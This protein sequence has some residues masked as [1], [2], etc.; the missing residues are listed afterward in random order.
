[1]I[2]RYNYTGRKRI[3]RSDV[4]VFVEDSPLRFEIAAFLSEYKL[5][6]EAKVFV[7]AY[8]QTNWMRFDCGKVGE[9]HSGLTWPLTEFDTREGILF[10][11]RVSESESLQGRLLAEA[12][13]IFPNVR[14]GHDEEKRSPLLPVKPED[15]G[16]EV[17]RIDYGDSEPILKINNR[18][19]DWRVLALHDAFLSLVLPQLLRR[20]P[21]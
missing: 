20:S 7:E 16:D 21:F 9:F 4:Q 1:M 3:N 17:Y 14:G 5:P 11:L 8:R 12:D 10:R 6:S 18:F 15:L 13:Q 19:G 2:R